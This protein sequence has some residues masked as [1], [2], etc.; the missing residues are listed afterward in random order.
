MIREDEYTVLKVITVMLV[1]LAHI[2]IFFS[3]DGGVFPASAN[4]VLHYT[5]KVI[6]SFHMQLFFFLSGAIFK[7]CIQN[8]KYKRIFPFIINKAKRLMLPYIVWGCLYVAPIVTLLGITD[9]SFGEYV[10]K[11]ILCNGD[12]RHLWY[13]WALFFIFIIA[14][15]LVPILE[16]NKYVQIIV[17]VLATVLS[18]YAL[19]L[20][21]AFGISRILRYLQYFLW[22]YAFVEQKYWIDRLL[23]KRWYLSFFSAVLMTAFVVLTDNYNINFLLPYAGIFTCYCLVL[24]A[25]ERLVKLSIYQLVQKNSMGIYLLHPMIVYLLFYVYNQLD[26]NVSAESI[27]CLII[28]VITMALS[29]WITGIL[30]K[31]KW[32]FLLGE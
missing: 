8:E 28:L 21:P 17:A 20:T 32:N 31:H 4:I 24:N 6:Y 25:K 13:L 14:R 18:Y 15:M 23:N 29:I 1:V 16:K 10:L 30:K 9:V 26:L 19:D 3:L 22:G 7:C 5:T 12:S 2:T 11:G 27:L